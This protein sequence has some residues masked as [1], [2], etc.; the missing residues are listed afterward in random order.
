MRLID[1]GMNMYNYTPIVFQFRF[2]AIDSPNIVF[3]IRLPRLF[4]FRFGA[5]DSV[6]GHHN[7]VILLCFNSGLVRLIE[8]CVY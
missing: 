2:G 7:F 1:N 5:I 6:D 3:F 4:Q 8:K